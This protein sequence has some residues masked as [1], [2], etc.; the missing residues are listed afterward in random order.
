MYILD[1]SISIFQVFLFNG[2]FD[3]VGYMYWKLSFQ[4]FHLWNAANIGVTCETI[5][6]VMNKTIL[7]G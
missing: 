1:S 4:V 2:L 7:E 6:L 3:T 5:W